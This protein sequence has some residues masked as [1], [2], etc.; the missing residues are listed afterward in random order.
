[1]EINVVRR[2]TPAECYVYRRRKNRLYKGALPKYL[3]TP[4]KLVID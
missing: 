3:H 1:M 2:C 4:L